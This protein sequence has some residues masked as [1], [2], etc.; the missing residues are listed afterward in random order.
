MERV[1]CQVG[2]LA[3]DAG[4]DNMVSAMQLFSPAKYQK[5]VKRFSNPTNCHKIKC[6]SLF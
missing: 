5:Y 4:F 1:A 3:K 2:G 6:G